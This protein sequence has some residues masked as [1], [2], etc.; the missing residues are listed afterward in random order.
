MSNTLPL[1]GVR[2]LEKGCLLSARLTTLLFADQGADVYVLPGSSSKDGE[3]I[4]EYLNRNKILIPSLDAV[5]LASV[6]MIIVDGADDSIARLPHQILLRVV[7]ALTGDSVYGHLPHDVDEDYLSALTGFFTDMAM[8]KWLDRWVIY[9][10]L[11]VCSVYTGVIGAVSCISAL[12]DRGRCGQGREIEASRLACGLSAIGALSLKTEGLPEHLNAVPISQHRKGL[13]D[14]KLD[15]FKKAA[16][17]DPARQ[18]WLD[19]QLYPFAAPYPTKDGSLIL[20]MATF[21]RR[22]A[23]NYCKY[24][25]IMESIKKAGIVDKDPFVPAN[26]EYVYCNLALPMNMD[27]PSSSACAELLAT[28]FRQKTASEW[29]EELEAAGLPCAKVQTF[30][31]YLSETAVREAGI[32]ADVDG[33][34]KPQ[35]GRVAWVKSAGDYPNLKGAQFCSRVPLHTATNQFGSAPVAKRPLE[36]FV[37]ADMSNVIAGPNC[38]RMFAELGA[39]VYKIGPHN[40]QHGPMVMLVWQAEA[41]QGK[42]SIIL[43]MKKPEGLSVMKRIVGR[44]DIVLFNKMDDQLESL[45]LDEASLKA[46]NPNLIGLQLKAHEGEKKSVRSNWVG[47]DPALQGKTGLMTRFGPPGAPSFHGVASCVDY[48]TGYLSV[49]AGLLALYGRETRKD[50]TADW[51][52]TSLAVAASLVQCTLQWKEPP[53]SAV[54]PFATGMNEHDRIYKVADGKCIYAKVDA[55]RSIKVAAAVKQKTREEAVQFLKEKMDILAV[56]VRT[57]REAADVAADLKSKTTKHEKRD[58]GQGWIVHTWSPTWFC[59]DGE[60]MTCPGAP[61]RAGSDA[62]DILET[63]GFDAEEIAYLHEVSAVGPAEWYHKD[64]K[65]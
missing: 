57:C 26:L 22:L 21:N 38:G 43:N 48:L 20:P 47:Y 5:D 6:D 8:S 50:G 30:Q 4:D 36:G 54:G 44:S 45:G 12:V 52:C 3:P 7:A 65:E 42:K 13:S 17:A 29:E 14:E 49:W 53:P 34:D 37:V 23:V 11:K 58:A 63:M 19:Q 25:G 9:T 59:F 62:N 27:F 51:A 60:P 46:L 40:P 41:H 18:L 24:L 35:L 39:T 56:P 32:V 31:Q 55:D 2:V 15:E 33:L 16:I 28:A 64:S 61:T 1:A 10:P